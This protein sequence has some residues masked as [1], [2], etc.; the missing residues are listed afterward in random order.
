MTDRVTGSSRPARSVPTVTTMTPML[1]SSTWPRATGRFTDIKRTAWRLA[2]HGTHVGSNRVRGAD[3]VRDACQPLIPYSDV[4]DVPRLR[5]H[6]PRVPRR[7]HPLA[8][9]VAVPL[10]GGP[11][12]AERGDRG[13]GVDGHLRL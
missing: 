13:G 3:R 4:R 5:R 12:G 10:R 2:A 7:D 9:S 11:G 6:G 1:A 8:G